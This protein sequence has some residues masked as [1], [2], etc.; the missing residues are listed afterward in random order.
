MDWDDLKTRWQAHRGH[1]EHHW[2]RISERE[3]DEIA[4]DR[5]RLSQRIQEVYRVSPEDAEREIAAWEMEHS[6]F[7]PSSADGPPPVAPGELARTSAGAASAPGADRLVDT[8]TYPQQPAD[9]AG[10]T[11]YIDAESTPES[12]EHASEAPG[13]SRPRKPAR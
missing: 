6:N 2:Q 3:F 8:R 5:Q 1:L 13:A 12:N 11:G 7:D 9:G 4:G 10:S